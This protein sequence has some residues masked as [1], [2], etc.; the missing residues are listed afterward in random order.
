MNSSTQCYW[1]AALISGDC[2][3]DFACE[4]PYEVAHGVTEGTDSMPGNHDRAV[5]LEIATV[6]HKLHAFRDELDDWLESCT[7]QGRTYAGDQQNPRLLPWDSSQEP[8]LQQLVQAIARL[9]VGEEVAIALNSVFRNILGANYLSIDNCSS[10]SSSSNNLPATPLT[11]PKGQEL[12]RSDRSANHSSAS[13]T[14]AAYVGSCLLANPPLGLNQ[15]IDAEMLLQWEAQDCCWAWRLT[16]HNQEMGW[17]I[18]RPQVKDAALLEAILQPARTAFIQRVAALVGRYLSHARSYNQFQV[19]AQTLQT[20]NQELQQISQLKSEFLANTSHEI[21]TPLSSI[22]GFTHLLREQG[23]NPGSLRHQEYLKI[24]LTSGQHLLALINDILDLS[25]IEANQ[26]DL[27]WERVELEPLCRT[28][29]TLVQEKA[30][31]RGLSL[32]LDIPDHLSAIM[33]DP[34][35]LKQ[36]LFNL[37]SNALKFTSEGA[38]GLRVAQEG[39]LM[40]LTVWDTGTGIP[41]EQQNL[42][43]KPYQQL[44]NTVTSSTEGT[45][46]GL[47]LTQKLAELHGGWVELQSELNRGSAFTVVIPTSLPSASD[48]GLEALDQSDSTPSRSRFNSQVRCADSSLSSASAPPKTKTLTENYSRQSAQK[49][50][51]QT[52][53]QAEN[54]I[55][56]QQESKR[57][58]GEILLVEDNLFNAQLLMTYLGKLGYQ[59]S[60]AKDSEE[61]WQSLAHSLPQMILMDINLPE[62]D[63]LTLIRQLRSQACYQELPIIAQT[64]MAM[65]GDRETCLTAGATDY[66][67]KPIDLKK[68]ALLIAQYISQNISGKAP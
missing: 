65:S 13:Y 62:V 63:G 29:L 48:L 36:I 61:M 40:R 22:L 24:I 19:Q 47:A 23:F 8:L 31:D 51:S 5:G 67:A 56:Q 59:V 37:L 15:A 12:G 20:R 39:E 25:K 14:L 28:V 18:V 32:K 35:R 46:L 16:V 6:E 58:S 57:V 49:I 66:V 50:A 53:N 64:A 60:W 54:L 68:L 4:V 7:V 52:G 2:N 9:L 44:P 21:R 26:L 11:Y 27:H 45:G 42:L 1:A 55:E 43:F 34:L 10:G 30:N 38:V 3:Q 33:A 41:P 17:L